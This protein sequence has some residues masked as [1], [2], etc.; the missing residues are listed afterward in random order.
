MEYLTRPLNIT[1]QVTLLTTGA[2]F[3]A[4]LAAYVVAGLAGGSTPPL[5]FFVIS[6]AATSVIGALIVGLIV[7]SKQRDLWL[8][9]IAARKMGEGDLS[10]PIRTN[11]KVEEVFFLAKVLEQNRISIQEMVRELAIA[12]EWS[13][14][15]R[16]V[17]AYFLAN[18]SHEFRTPLAGMKVS[19]EL[20]LDNLRD[21]SPSE[22][23]ELLNS[24]HL[25][26]SSMSQLIDNLLESSKIEAEQLTLRPVNTDAEKLIVDSARLAQPFLHRRGQRLSIDIPLTP[27]R[28]QADITRLIQVL[29]NLLINASKYS[30]AGGVIDVAVERDEAGTRITIAD[31]GAGIP[32]DKRDGVFKRFVR[33]GSTASEDYGAGLGLS[34]VKAIIQAHG[35]T[36]GVDARDGGGSKFWFTLPAA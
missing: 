6:L 27:T 12:K 16:S 20:L 8:L 35:G 29:V 30:P 31:R 33:L 18:I 2:I 25:S 36:V 5:L 3:G 9:A 23:D 14:S 4:G 34:V 32:A 22:L 11:G 24:L 19:L 1:R 26:V 28:V 10:T 21:L 7:R 13:D 15:Q 17:Q